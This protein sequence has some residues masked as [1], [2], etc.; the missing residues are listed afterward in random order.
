MRWLILALWLVASVGGA[1]PAAT[2]PDWKLVFREEFNGAKDDLDA[3]WKFQNGPSGHILC[4]RWRD[5]VVVTNGLCR[6]VNRKEKRGGQDW[7]SGNLWTKQQFQY[8]YFE[9]RYRYAAAKAT[10]NSFWLMPTGK[11]PPGMKH[12]EIDINEGHYPNEVTSNIHNH[13]DVTIVNGKRTH[14]TSGRSYR[15][16]VRPDTTIQ[17]ETPVRTSR[18]RFSSACGFC[19]HLGEFRIYDAS[20]VGYPDALSPSADRDKPGLVNLARDSSTRITTSGFLKDGS[21]TSANMVDGKIETSWTSQRNGEKWV[22]FTFPA[23]RTVGCVQFVAGY[24]SK[25]EW[26]GLPG[27]YRVAYHDGR[28]WV[29]MA[30]FDV[31][32]GAYNFA[33]GFHIFGLQWSEQELVFYLDGREI[34]REK[35]EFCRSPAPVWLSEAI[36]PWAGE[37][38][39]AIDGTAMDVDYVR[40]YRRSP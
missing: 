8:G 28:K 22:E 7:T 31:T 39:D 24:K 13:S 26:T 36:I 25:G 6:L 23:E 3:N 30:S 1:A 20:S 19:L 33:R 21:D 17:L 10:N 32:R 16:G 34:R 11:V 14:P 5:N 29:E 4:S 38:T 35:N 18:L 15:F 2:R 12:F 40:V 37:V 27:D 9:C